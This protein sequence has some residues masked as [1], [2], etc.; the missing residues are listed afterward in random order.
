M[1]SSSYDRRKLAELVKEI[2]GERTIRQYANDTGIS[3]SIISRILSEDYKPGAEMI[4]RLVKKSS[5]PRGNVTANDLMVAAGYLERDANK[6][7]I[8]SV[9]S[10]GGASLATVAALSLAMVSPIAA[11]PASQLAGKVIG[12]TLA[13][14]QYKKAKAEK[15]NNNENEIP[16]EDVVKDRLVE[17]E[18]QDKEFI[19]K[20]MRGIMLALL[21][22]DNLLIGK[23]DIN[24]LQFNVVPDEV[25]KI[26]NHNIES[27]WFKFYNCPDDSDLL[28]LYTPQALAIA[29]FGGFV[30]LPI[31]AKR[32]ISFV[33]NSDKLYNEFIK[34]KGNN[35]YKGNISVI[36]IDKTNSAI[37]KEEFISYFDDS[38]SEHNLLKII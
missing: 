9:V 22:N 23:D 31:D 5:K 12:K 13:D 20:S 37:L 11:I 15:I 3:P 17:H 35:S 2:K 21:E 18:K 33:I 32:K 30:T 10:I 16:K 19:K 6:E 1:S 38:D 27:W 14:M 34:F 7:L 4:K 8:D 28:E 24:S 36:L 29:L 25:L 26:S